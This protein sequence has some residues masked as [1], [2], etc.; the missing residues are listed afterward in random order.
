MDELVKVIKKLE[1]PMGDVRTLAFVMKNQDQDFLAH[2]SIP[3]P[4]VDTEDLTPKDYEI[5]EVLLGRPMVDKTKVLV[6]MGINEV[7]K[8]MDEDESKLIMLRRK[9]RHMRAYSHGVVGPIDLDN[10]EIT[11]AMTLEMRDKG[12]VQ[13]DSFLGACQKWHENFEDKG[14]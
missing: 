13:I 2:I 6:A 4:H 11:L 10:P 5:K 7:F 3:P 1:P 8:H 12:S 9:K 14:V